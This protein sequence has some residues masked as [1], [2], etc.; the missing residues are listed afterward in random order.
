[1]E[2]NTD[3]YKTYTDIDCEG[4]ARRLMTMLGRHIDDPAKTNLYWEKF[5]EKLARARRGEAG[6]GDELFLIHASIN[7]I[8]DYLEELEDGEALALLDRIEVEC[9]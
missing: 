7:V 4:N 5:K 6:A 1:M 2:K 8:R 9:C 3:R